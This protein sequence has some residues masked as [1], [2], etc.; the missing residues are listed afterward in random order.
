MDMSCPSNSAKQACACGGS[1]G[2]AAKPIQPF[3][4]PEDDPEIGRFMRVFQP[5]ETFDAIEIALNK[6][7]LAPLYDLD[8]HIENLTEHYLKPDAEYRKMY[9]NVILRTAQFFGFTE[10]EL[11]GYENGDEGIS[12][13]EREVLRSIHFVVPHIRNPIAHAPPRDVAHLILMDLQS[14]T[15]KRIPMFQYAG[16]DHKEG[17]PDQI[18]G[19]PKYSRR[20]GMELL[21]MEV[22]RALKSGGEVPADVMLLF[23]DIIEQHG[24]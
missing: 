5:Y 23:P 11:Q 4:T 19:F 3:S 9:Q 2:V 17:H 24:L 13:T 21:R 7:I 22:E 16:H 6:L 1:T 14:A 20:G 10:Q 8:R 18:I 12:G 15:E